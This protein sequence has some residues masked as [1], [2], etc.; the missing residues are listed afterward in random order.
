[1]RIRDR[2]G[3]AVR[4]Y[5]AEIRHEARQLW[6]ESREDHRDFVAQWREARHW[7]LIIKRKITG[8]QDPTRADVRRAV[9]EYR[10]EN[11]S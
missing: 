7:D 2:I 1:M 3:L 9:R 5:F 10:K 11:P 8:K 4:G 6:L